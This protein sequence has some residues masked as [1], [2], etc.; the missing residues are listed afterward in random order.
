MAR[1]AAITS[2]SIYLAFVSRMKMSCG[3]IVYKI[4]TRSSQYISYVSQQLNVYHQ[5]LSSVFPSNKP[6]YARLGVRVG[7][8]RYNVVQN[9]TAFAVQVKGGEQGA[10]ALWHWSGVMCRNLD[11][12]PPSTDKPRRLAVFS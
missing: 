6:G 2:R 5:T 7:T 12:L 4:R 3:F 9:M 8:Y 10:T 11:G 1:L